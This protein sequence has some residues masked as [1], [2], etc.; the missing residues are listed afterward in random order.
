[1]NENTTD[2]Q[3]HVEALAKIVELRG[4]LQL[5]GWSGILQIFISR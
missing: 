3:I 5:L 2:L 4:G 1:M